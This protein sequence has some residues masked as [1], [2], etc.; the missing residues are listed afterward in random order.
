MRRPVFRSEERDEAP[1]RIGMSVGA[2]PSRHD[3][4][5]AGETSFS[6][7]RS[8][9]PQDEPHRGFASQSVFFRGTYPPPFDTCAHQ[10]C[11]QTLE[12]KSIA[13]GSLSERE[14]AQVIRDDDARTI[15]LRVITATTTM[16]WFGGSA[17][18]AGAN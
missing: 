6:L 14:A 16:R 17:R 3:L 8:F 2:A 15:L 10:N 18:D 12:G 13:R 7:M 1:K 4:A 5:R 9:L 11:G